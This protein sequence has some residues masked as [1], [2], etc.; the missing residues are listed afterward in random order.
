MQSEGFLTRDCLKQGGG[1]GPSLL[2]LIIDDTKDVRP[3]IKKDQVEWVSKFGNCR[4]IRI[5]LCK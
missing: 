2:L 1:L 3:S 4:D 5:S